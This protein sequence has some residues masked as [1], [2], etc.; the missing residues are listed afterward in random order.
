MADRPVSQFTASESAPDSAQ[1]P[2]AVPGDS[3]NYRISFDALST[4]LAAPVSAPG[5]LFIYW[6]G[7]HADDNPPPNPALNYERRFSNGDAPVIWNPA[8]SSWV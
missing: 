5:I 2:F 6:Q 3:H 1:F 4:E 7:T 8:I